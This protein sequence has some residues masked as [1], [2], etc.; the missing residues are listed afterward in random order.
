MGIFLFNFSTDKQRIIIWR[1]I[2]FLALSA[3]M[4]LALLPT[5]GAQGFSGQDKLL[6]CIT[7][8]VLFLMAC[9]CYPDQMYR[10]WLYLGLFFYGVS[11][12]L[13]QGQTAYRSMEMLDLVADMLG[14]ALGCL[15]LV[16]YARYSPK[17]GSS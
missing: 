12:E 5:S 10:K 3:V 9:Q 13:L 16:L 1:L 4:T 7:F 6:H 15:F 17:H 2:F 11:M 14:V 8:A